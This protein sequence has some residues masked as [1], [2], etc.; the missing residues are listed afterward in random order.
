MTDIP[1]GSPMAAVIRGRS[2]RSANV[3][4]WSLLFKRQEA[5][6]RDDQGRWVCGPRTIAAAQRQDGQQR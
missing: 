1:K 6:K 5:A 4:L 2:M 3:S